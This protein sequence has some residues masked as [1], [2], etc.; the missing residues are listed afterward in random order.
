MVHSNYIDTRCTGQI[1]KLEKKCSKI[2]NN[3]FIF[4][5]ELHSKISQTIESE[6]KTTFSEWILCEL[7]I[8]SI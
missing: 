7:L 8:N 3:L 4:Q 6:F 2:D 5:I 1:L